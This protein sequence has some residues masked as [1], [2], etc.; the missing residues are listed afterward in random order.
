M[1]I[2]RDN[3]KRDNV[4]TATAQQIE[5]IIK[6]IAGNVMEKI[7]AGQMLSTNEQPKDQQN[8][9]AALQSYNAQNLGYAGLMATLTA[10]TPGV[11][12]ASWNPNITSDQTTLASRLDR[13]IQGGQ[14]SPGAMNL[15]E[16]AQRIA[17]IPPQHLVRIGNAMQTNNKE[18]LR[19]AL[20]AC[21]DEFTKQEQGRQQPQEQQPQQKEP[22]EMDMRV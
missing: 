21:R 14:Q 5:G 10:G 16:V 19:G 8:N 15:V 4:D 6:G 1:E 11:I 20:S 9:M 22:K 17:Q 3:M 18:E 7:N 2:T 12:T 13:A